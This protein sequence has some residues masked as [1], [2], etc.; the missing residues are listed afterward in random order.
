[1]KNYKLPKEFA[2]KLI[3]A[4]RSGKY[5]QGGANLL[6]YEK[7]DDTT[8]DFNK[9]LY[10]CLGVACAL[11]GVKESIYNR[12][13]FVDKNSNINVRYMLEKGYPKEL[14]GEKN[15]PHI[16]SMLN[17]GDAGDEFNFKMYF[18]ELNL[19]KPYTIGE[20]YKLNFNEIADFIEDNI[21]FY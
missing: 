14:V 19:R 11:T 15:L 8:V 3:A 6:S 5:E 17:D 10:C 21:E 1:M 13:S 7:L 12:K 2:E 18:G 16:L 9:K 4:L 20:V